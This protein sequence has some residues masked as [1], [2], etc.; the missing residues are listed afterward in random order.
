[1]NS[2]KK[3]FLIVSTCCCAVTMQVDK[4]QIINNRVDF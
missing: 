3:V 4:Q 1:M 2:Q